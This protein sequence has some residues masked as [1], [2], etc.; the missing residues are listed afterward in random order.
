[1]VAFLDASIAID[2][3][4]LGLLRALFAAFE[5]VCTEAGPFEQPVGNGL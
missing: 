2:L 1:M 3:Q 4:K 5:D